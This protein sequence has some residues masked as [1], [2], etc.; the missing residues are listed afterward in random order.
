MEKI[1]NI[2]NKINKKNKIVNI[3]KIFNS[4]KKNLRSLNFE[5]TIYVKKQKSIISQDEFQVETIHI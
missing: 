4:Q 3:K 1:E 5:N 2:L